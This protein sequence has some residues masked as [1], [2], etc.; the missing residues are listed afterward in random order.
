MK[1]SLRELA[2]SV[3][4]LAAVCNKLEAYATPS[5]QAAQPLA[6]VEEKTR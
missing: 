6:K 2:R 4:A 3:T 5:I 1:T